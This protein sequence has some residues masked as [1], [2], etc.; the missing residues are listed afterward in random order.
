MIYDTDRYKS[1]QQ[2]MSQR[3]RIVPPGV[4]SSDTLQAYTYMYTYSRVNSY[5]LSAA[6]TNNRKY[7]NDSVFCNKMV[8][9]GYQ[10]L[11]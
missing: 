5:L 3:H 8:V 4:S 9:R 2:L 6:I 1:E 11:V 10:S 7:A